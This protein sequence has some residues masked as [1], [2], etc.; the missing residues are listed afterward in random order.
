MSLKQMLYNSF[1]K[2]LDWV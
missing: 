1:H 2:P